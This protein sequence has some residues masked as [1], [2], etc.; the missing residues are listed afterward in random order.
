MTE[1]TINYRFQVDYAEHNENKIQE[2]E[3]FNRLSTFKRTALFL[4]L[5]YS[6]PSI[7]QNFFFTDIFNVASKIANENKD[8]TEDEVKIMDMF[9]YK[10]ENTI[11]DAS[12]TLQY[13]YDTC[14]E[15]VI[16]KF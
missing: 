7:V 3:H 9:Q 6:E 5:F 4:A 1:T 2:K 10:N 11:N 16:C 12:I 8:F 15:N 14:V 13:V